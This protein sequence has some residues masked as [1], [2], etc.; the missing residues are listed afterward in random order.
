MKSKSQFNSELSN[1]VHYKVRTFHFQRLSAERKKLIFLAYSS[2]Q[3]SSRQVFGSARALPILEVLINVF[4]LATWTDYDGYSSHF[5]Y[6]MRTVKQ[7]NGSSF[8]LAPSTVTWTDMIE[9]RQLCPWNEIMKKMLWSNCSYFDTKN[10]Q[11]EHYQIHCTYARAFSLRSAF[12]ECLDTS[13][14]WKV[15]DY[16]TDI[17]SARKPRRTENKNKNPNRKIFKDSSFSFLHHANIMKINEI[18]IQTV[19]WKHD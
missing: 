2:F 15:C 18:E 5:S 16:F 19:W 6:I 8:P 7:D 13:V 14:P 11:P 17:A 1:S 9:C 12:S 4:L 3:S 10:V